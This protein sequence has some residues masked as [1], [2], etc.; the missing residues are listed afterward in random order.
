MTVSSDPRLKIVFDAI[1]AVNDEDPTPETG[2]DG[3]PV[4]AALLYGQRMHSELLRVAPD[5]GDLLRIAARGQH[6]ARWKRPRADYPEGREGYLNWR[7]DL[8]AY[9]ATRV[10]AIMASAGYEAEDT[11]KVGRMLRKEGIKRDP[12]VQ[13]LEDVICL[14]FLRWYFAPFA[15]K[16]EPDAILRIVQ[17]TARKMSAEGRALALSEFDLPPDLAAAFA[18]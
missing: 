8:G 16:H 13:Q 12:D 5:A 9:H 6:I 11:E 14:V 18:G 1:D 15:A 3:H 2:P 17:K 7:R 4:P 10:G